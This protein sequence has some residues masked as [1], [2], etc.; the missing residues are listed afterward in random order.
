MK[1]SMRVVFLG[2]N[3]L[4]EVEGAEVFVTQVPNQ[5]PKGAF[6]W[7]FCGQNLYHL[8]LNLMNLVKKF[9]P[10]FMFKFHAMMNCKIVCAC[11]Y[12]GQSSTFA[13]L[14]RSATLQS[15]VRCES[16]KKIMK[17]CSSWDDQKYDALFVPPPGFVTEVI[18]CILPSEMPSFAE[19]NFHVCI[20]LL[21]PHLGC[22][23][24]I[25]EHIPPGCVL[26]CLVG[27]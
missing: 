27:I 20:F 16:G 13:E 25:Q 8:I 18:L 7:V 10:V 11:F 15:G 6:V 1:S 4:Q 19:M 14:K 24:Q 5:A 9:V 23:K 12:C 26:G 21:S 22:F 17:W 2:G 3:P